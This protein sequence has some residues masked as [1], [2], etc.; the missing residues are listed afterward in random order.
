MEKKTAAV[1]DRTVTASDIMPPLP[2][3][4]APTL[5]AE[6]RLVVLLASAAQEGG[7]LS[8]EAWRRA[9][10]ALEEVFAPQA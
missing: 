9:S 5:S 2:D 8:P 4:S 3:A 10:D 1:S 6:D 7:R